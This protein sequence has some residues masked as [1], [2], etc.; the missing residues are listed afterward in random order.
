MECG[1]IGLPNVGKTA[2]FNLLTDNSAQSSNYPYTTIEPNNGIAEYKDSRL[3][4]LAEL[5]PSAS[6]YY[7]RIKFIDIAGLPPGASKGEGLGNQFL[8]NIRGATSILHIVRGFHSPNVAKFNEQKSS[9]HNDWELVRTELFLSDYNIAERRIKENPESVYWK[10][11]L[12]NIKKQMPPATDDEGILI[13]PKEEIIVVNISTGMK[14]LHINGS[15]IITIDVEFQRELKEMNREERQNFTKD[16]AEWES[17]AGTILLEVKKL[18]NMVTFF[19]L[20][21]GKEVKG[22]NI[23]NGTTAYE[24]AGKIHT[25]IQKGFIKAKVYNFENLQKAEFNISELNKHGKIRT[26]GKDY[27][28]RD[29][30]IVE[31]MFRGVGA[32][33]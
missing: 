22:Y 7:P 13:T 29:G 11:V 20:V 32:K 17:S 3:T 25:D 4:K 6:L 10:E 9:L 27:V 24:A 16:M 19:T 21:G 14:K 18:L 33:T 30:D 15:K 28:I 5:F 12:D 31:V 2:L 8:S 1:I 26:E 23:K